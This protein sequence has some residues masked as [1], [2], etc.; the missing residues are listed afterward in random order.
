MLNMRFACVYSVHKA[1]IQ[2]GSTGVADRLRTPRMHCRWWCWVGGG[3]KRK[4]QLQSFF[5]QVDE[6]AIFYVVA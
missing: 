6:G 3:E 1:D 5:K 4:L 2:R